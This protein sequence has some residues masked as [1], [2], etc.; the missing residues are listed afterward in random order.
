ML[1]APGRSA[2]RYA[3]TLAAV[4]WLV[5]CAVS[6]PSTTSPTSAR[7]RED[8]LADSEVAYHAAA[9]PGGRGMEAKLIAKDG[10]V[11]V[12][13]RFDSSDRKSGPTHGTMAAEEYR[14]IWQ[15]AEQSGIWTLSVPGATAGADAVDYALRVRIGERVHAVTW[16][17]R[18][19]SLPEAQVAEG[20]GQKVIAA[21]RAATAR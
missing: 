16:N 10:R 6:T 3:P 18:T 20:L 5:A 2:P 1:Q 14:T 4:A 8:L 11:T 9:G 21:A 19:A 15:K 7:A 13:L 12:E 17:Q